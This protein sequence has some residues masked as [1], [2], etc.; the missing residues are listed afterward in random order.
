MEKFNG[1]IFAKLAQIGTRYEGPEYFLQ[2]FEKEK[3]TTEIPIRKKSQLWEIDHQLHQFL[4]QKVAIKGQLKNKS[5]IYEEIERF[6]STS[7]EPENQLELSLKFEGRMFSE[8]KQVLYVNKMVSP[9]TPPPPLPEVLRITLHYKWPGQSNYRKSCPTSQFSDFVIKDPNGNTI[10]QWSN[11]I[12]F[13]DKETAF[14]LRG[15]HEYSFPV[16]W[17]YFSNAVAISGEYLVIASFI[18]TGQEVSKILEIKFA[19]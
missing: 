7:P 19:H 3:N 13:L 2:I 4:A 12:L 10:W 17:N 8:A 16:E 6:G 9:I 1:F 11:S 18:A 14:E 15:N 5:I